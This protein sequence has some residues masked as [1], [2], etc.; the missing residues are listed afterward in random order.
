MSDA[1]TTTVEVWVLVDAVGDV[2]IGRDEDEVN[3]RWE[4]NIGTGGGNRRMV[5]VTLTVPLPRVQ[6]LTAVIPAVDDEPAE[7]RVA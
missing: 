2:E 5:R 4:D 7:L 1:K 3:T 6:E